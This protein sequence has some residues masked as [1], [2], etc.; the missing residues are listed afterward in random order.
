MNSAPV[1]SDQAAVNAILELIDSILASIS[2]SYEIERR[3][4]LNFEDEYKAIKAGLN[5]RLNDVDHKITDLKQRIAALNRIIK[6]CEDAIAEHT[7]K[8][9][10][11]TEIRSKLL[12]ECDAAGVAY[13]EERE[14]R[15][16]KR[17]VIS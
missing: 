13:A 9:E 6:Q 12:D 3:D 16:A 1:Q 4:F 2:E 10:Q 17:E 7:A 14:S 15:D 5:K 8:V 11:K